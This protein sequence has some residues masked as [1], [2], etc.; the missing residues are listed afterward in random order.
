M[1]EPPFLHLQDGC[2]NPY[3]ACFTALSAERGDQCPLGTGSHGRS[4]PQGSPLLP[5]PTLTISSL[6]FLCRTLDSATAVSTQA[7]KEQ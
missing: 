2:D 4:S 1:P 3:A 5:R 7:A 6:P